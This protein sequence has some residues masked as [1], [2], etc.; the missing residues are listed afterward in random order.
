MKM[1]QIHPLA[2]QRMFKWMDRNFNA[3]IHN[4]IPFITTVVQRNWHYIRVD[5]LN[6]VGNSLNA[7]TNEETRDFLVEV[8]DG[9]RFIFRY[10]IFITFENIFKKLCNV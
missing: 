2:D 1:M 7:K 9:M 4:I 6:F 3:W 8:L 5:A 10:T